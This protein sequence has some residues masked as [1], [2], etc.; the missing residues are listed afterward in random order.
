MGIMMRTAIG[1]LLGI[2]LIIIGALYKKNKKLG[3]VLLVL[4]IVLSVCAIILFVF[5][6][7]LIGNM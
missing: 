7:F 3:R 6:F 5:I 2:L 4:G 1:L